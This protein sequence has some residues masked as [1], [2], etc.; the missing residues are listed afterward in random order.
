VT[1]PLDRIHTEAVAAG[2]AVVDGLGEFTG[3]NMTEETGLLLRTIG[4]TGTANIPT[5]SPSFMDWV[6]IAKLS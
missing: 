4:L 2:F 3:T 5:V 6:A 1:H